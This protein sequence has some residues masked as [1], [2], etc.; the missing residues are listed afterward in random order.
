MTCR[1]DGEAGFTFG[2]TTAFLCGR[3]MASASRFSPIAIGDLAIFS[4]PADGTG[5]AERLTK[6]DRG[7]TCPESWSP[8]GDTFLF[9]VTKGADMSL[10]AFSLQ[11]MKAVPF[12]AV[13][14]SAVI[15][16][17]SHRWTMEAYTS[18]DQNPTTISV[19]PFPA[20][21]AKH[22][23]VAGQGDSPH[24]VVWSPDGR[25]SVH[26]PRAGGFEAVG[27]TT[28]L[29]FLAFVGIPQVPHPFQPGPG[30]ARRSYDITPSGKFVGLLPAGQKEFRRSPVPQIQV[31]S[32]GSRSPR[33]T[34]RSS[35]DNASS[36]TNQ[37]VEDSNG[38]GDSRLAG[39][40]PYSTHGYGDRQTRI[41]GESALFEILMRR[42]NQRVYRVVRLS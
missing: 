41:A 16:P 9:S 10:W 17:C 14:S 3:G 6:P 24:M 20:T 26:D 40:A 23:L 19:Q 7:V 38:H 30:S 29:T 28:Q 27:V 22:Q 5:V 4:Q 13:Q 33:H 37:V 8:K 15:M 36:A 32:T 35:S 21:G 1:H 42:H 11:D 31:N 18:T 39:V 25:E 12:G 2:G 34:R